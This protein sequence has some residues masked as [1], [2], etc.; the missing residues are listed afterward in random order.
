M[1]QFIHLTK[2]QFSSSSEKRTPFL[3]S[4]ISLFPEFVNWFWIAHQSFGWNI[5]KSVLCSNHF[6]CGHESINT[7]NSSN[8]TNKIPVKWIC[9]LFIGFKHRLAKDN[10]CIFP[11]LSM[12]VEISWKQ[13]PFDER[14]C[15]N[16]THSQISFNNNNQANEL[17]DSSSALLA[18]YAENFD[19]NQ[20]PEIFSLHSFYFSFVYLFCSN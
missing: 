4:V 13:I 8:H 15:N 14:K 5:N 10:S 16:N 6:Q 3:F 17:S 9:P 19:V 2:T 1:F 7:S 11:Q 18:M 12:L 20:P